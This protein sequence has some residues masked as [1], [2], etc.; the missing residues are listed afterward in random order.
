MRLYYNAWIAR[1]VSSLTVVAS[2][3]LVGFLGWKAVEIWKSDPA[4]QEMREIL[5]R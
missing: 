5:Q 2:L 4:I 3:A 1:V